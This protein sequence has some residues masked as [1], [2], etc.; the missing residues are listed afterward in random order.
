MSTDGLAAFAGYQR[1]REDLLTAGVKIFELRPDAAV[2]TELMTGPPIP[3]AIF[4]LHAKTMVVDSETLMVGTFNLDPRSANLNTE[5]VTIV[6]DA[7]LAR[8][9][10][11][12]IV[13]EMSSENA[14]PCTEK[15]NPDQYASWWKR[16]RVFMW[17]LVPKS[18]L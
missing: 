13:K 8:V 7:D 9:T 10:E 11:A 17:R 12:Q 4:G 16:F 5:G 18:L 15:H 6:N 14:W 2:R 1:S 3:D